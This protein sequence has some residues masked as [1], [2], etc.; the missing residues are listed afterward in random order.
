MFKKLYCSFCK[1]II[2]FLQ[3]KIKDKIN[4]HPFFKKFEVFI[5]KSASFFMKM[6][7]GGRNKDRVVRYFQLVLEESSDPLCNNC[8]SYSGYP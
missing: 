3:I 4:F 8:S 1:K 5:L 2:N 6:K 7:A